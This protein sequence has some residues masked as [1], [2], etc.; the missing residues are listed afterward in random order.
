ML[1]IALMSG[2]CVVAPC[3]DAVVKI[4]GAEMTSANILLFRFALQAVLLLPL[5]WLMRRPW[6]ARGRPLRLTFLRTLLHMAGVYFMIVSL[7]YLPLADAIAIAFVMPFLTLLAGSFFLGEEIGPRRMAAVAVGFC[8]TLLVIQPSFVAVGWKALLPLLVA[9]NF[10]AFSLVTRQVARATDPIAM[11][12]V[13]GVMATVIL[14]PLMLLA[15]AL[16]LPGMAYDTPPLHLWGLV[17]LTGLFGSFGHLLMTWSLR[18]APA[19]TL[20]PMQYLELPMTAVIGWLVFRE[21]PNGLALLGIGIII[22][23]GLYIILRERSIARSAPEA[24][25]PHPPAPP[26]VP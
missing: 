20:A 13:S 2:F 5:V 21:F 17:L 8:G 3:A 6:P 7:R 11:Q 10:T 9:V 25:L 26:P 14:V 4:L 24:P 1:G 16:S 19:A 23:A 22:A 15:D 12:A 18:F